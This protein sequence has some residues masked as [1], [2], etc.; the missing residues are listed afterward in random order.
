M[1][2]HC[3][4]T[5]RACPPAGSSSASAPAGRGSALAGLPRRQWCSRS[6][7][8]RRPDR[9]GR[10]SGPGHAAPCPPSPFLTSQRGLSGMSKAPTKN[11]S[12]GAAT[13][14]NIQRQPL[15]RSRPARVD[16]RVGTR[17][18]HFDRQST[19]SPP[20]PPRMPITIVSWLMA[21]SRP[22]WW[23]G[24]TSAMYIGDRFDA[25]PIA[26]PPRMRQTTNQ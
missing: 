10:R 4:S 20:A 14:V 2:L 3:W 8:L 22:R 13:A 1:P 21:T 24:A 7:A 18:R 26:T 15:A 19:S 25:M 23:A 17:V 6:R 11:S 12:E 5:A 9:P 16:R